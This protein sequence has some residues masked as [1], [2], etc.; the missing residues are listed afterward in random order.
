MPGPPLGVRKDGSQ[1]QHGPASTEVL[2]EGTGRQTACGRCRGGDAHSKENRHGFSNKM[3]WED[4]ATKG[5]FGRLEWNKGA[6]PVKICVRSS[7]GREER[8]RE[9]PEIG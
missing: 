5:P 1:D 6:G 8:K 7:P 9:V 3:F 2:R 4:L